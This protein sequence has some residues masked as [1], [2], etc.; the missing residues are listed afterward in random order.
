MPQITLQNVRYLLICAAGLLGMLMFVNFPYYRAQQRATVQADD[1]RL[2]LEEQ[3]VLYPIFVR[4]LSEMRR[5]LP[6]GI[7]IPPPQDLSRDAT[8]DLYRLVQELA[9]PFEL[10]VTEVMPDPETL[11]S[12]ADQFMVDVALQGEYGALQ[13]F[14][15]QVADWPYLS[16]IERI[17]LRPVEGKRELRLRLWLRREPP[18]SKTPGT[19]GRPA[20]PAPLVETQRS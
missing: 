7:T 20:P 12:T 11:F 15:R 17:Q 18:N 16:H 4:Y 1:L 19:D 6:E 9:R 8:S 10:I 2:Q 5:G 3:K 14:L 13:P